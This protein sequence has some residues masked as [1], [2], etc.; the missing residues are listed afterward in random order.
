[1]TERLFIA[2]KEHQNAGRLSATG[3]ALQLVRQRGIGGLYKG[4]GATMARD[5]TFSI[6]YF[7]LFAYLNSL[8]PRKK[9]GS[10]EAVFWASFVAGNA[11]GAFGATFVTP[12]DGNYF[13]FWSDAN[14]SS[15]AFC[16]F[17]VY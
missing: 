2:T 1:L 16:L 17:L 11:A 5:V 3:I 6:V 4:T 14:I 8:G 10:G 7:P 13:I 12:L 15:A 9:D